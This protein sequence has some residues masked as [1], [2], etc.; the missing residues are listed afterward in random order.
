MMEMGGYSSVLLMSHLDAIREIAHTRI[1]IQRS[2]DNFFSK[3]TWGKNYPVF[4]K[5]KKAEMDIS[6]PVVK[7]N[8]M[9][10]IS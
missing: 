8:R 5:N 10:K 2:E 3:I 6:A 1:D 9:K 4:Q 7:R